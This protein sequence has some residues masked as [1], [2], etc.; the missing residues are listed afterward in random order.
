MNTAIFEEFLEMY[1]TILF[2]AFEDCIQ[3]N[4]AS[5]SVSEIVT[6]LKTDQPTHESV[7]IQP[8]SLPV[9]CVKSVVYYFT[10]LTR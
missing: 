3:L 4:L 6:I 8:P 2:S 1:T 5:R 9:A 10:V 7:T